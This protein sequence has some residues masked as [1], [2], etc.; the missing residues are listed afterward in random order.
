VRSWADIR[1]AGIALSGL[2]VLAGCTFGGEPDVAAPDAEG[3]ASPPGSTSP[4]TTP[5]P[6]STES[7]DASEPAPAGS[8]RPDWLGT[9]VLPA[10]EDGLGEVQDT[11]P[12]LVDRRFP[13]PDA[14]PVD[15][16]FIATI[17][18]VPADVLA[19][20]TWHDECPVG[21]DE[22]RYLTMTF[23]GFDDRTYA[24]EMIVHAE[25]ADDVVGAF[26]QMYDARFPIE[27]MRVIAPEELDAPP[28][29]DG[30]TTTAF[31]CRDATLGDTW[32]QH[33]YGLAIDINPFHN[34]YERGDAVLPELASAY[35]D[36]DRDLPGMIQ[37]GGPVTQAFG[38]LGWGWGGQ[39]N[40]LKD[41]MHVSQNGR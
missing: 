6:A 32:S 26:E 10:R 30:N 1:K 16:E 8:I 20:S 19:R 11:P 41:Y 25:V 29:G 40:S 15:D 13:P 9:R 33:A 2:L 28:T 37:P 4:A 17:E 14:K 22:L 23:W 3:S 21:L 35:L 5:P 36:R 12:E 31:V 34:P 27:E 18:E 39:W 24:G 38:A 7:P